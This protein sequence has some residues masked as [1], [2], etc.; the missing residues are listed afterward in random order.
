MLVSLWENWKERCF[1]A[2][3]EVSTV[4]G[5]LIGD[6][7]WAE[8][9]LMQ[10]S[11]GDSFLQVAARLES[12][13]GESILPAAAEERMQSSCQ[14]FLFPETMSATFF[15]FARLWSFLEYARVF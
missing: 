1:R 10:V 3:K 12:S 14:T 9:E 15:F 7:F 8:R 13:C 5:G 6:I 2:D 4:S 11:C